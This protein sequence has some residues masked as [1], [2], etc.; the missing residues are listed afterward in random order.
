M[1]EAGLCVTAAQLT[2]RHKKA[3]YTGGTLHSVAAHT[4]TARAEQT[5]TVAALRQ[6]APRL[7]LV[8]HGW[9]VGDWLG[10]WGV[11][12]LAVGD[13]QSAP[14]STPGTTGR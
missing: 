11:G 1:V 13:A 5:E 10:T 9:G 8:P 2:D 4:R 12:V 6:M 7:R 3:S 14:G